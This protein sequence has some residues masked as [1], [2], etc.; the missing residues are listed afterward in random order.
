MLQAETAYDQ[1]VLARVQY[2]YAAASAHGAL[3]VTIGLPADQPLKL[4][5]QPV[6]AAVPE[7]AAKID[8]LMA[9]AKFSVRI[10]AALAQ[11]DAAEAN[12]TVARA[13]GR[14]SISFQGG[15]SG[16]DAT[17]YRIRTIVR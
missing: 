11:R 8:D 5:A 2:E 4:D 16:S 14:P 1:A 12:V 7:F 9:R 3:S 17:G 10:F 6:P 13:V 15:R